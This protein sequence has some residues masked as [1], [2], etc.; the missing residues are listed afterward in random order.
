[1]ELPSLANAE[2][3]IASVIDKNTPATAAITI[4]IDREQIFR[5]MTPPPREQN[6]TIQFRGRNGFS[7][8]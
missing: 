1:M 7:T 2:P 8:V 6:R 4:L 5:R 3:A